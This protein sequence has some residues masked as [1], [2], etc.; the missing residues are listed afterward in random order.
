VLTPV[1]RFIETTFLL[2]ELLDSEAD[3]PQ[4]LKKGEQELAGL[5]DC[6][7]HLP[8]EVAFGRLK[9]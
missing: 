4:S 9:K 8:A 7:S 5:S 2:L 3:T 1:L 6:S